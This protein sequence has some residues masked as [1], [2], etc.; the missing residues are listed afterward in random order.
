[1]QS[2]TIALLWQWHVNA[3]VDNKEMNGHGCVPKTLY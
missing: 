1:M 2:V 3:A